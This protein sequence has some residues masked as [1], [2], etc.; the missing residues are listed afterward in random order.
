MRYS[1]SHTK[2]FQNFP[3]YALWLKGGFSSSIILKSKLWWWIVLILSQSPLQIQILVH[4]WASKSS[5]PTS[6]RER[7][8]Y[9]WILVP[10]QTS[11]SS[12]NKFAFG[13]GF[14]GFWHLIISFTCCISSLNCK[15]SLNKNIDTTFNW[16]PQE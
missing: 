10:F 11:L 9:F 4:G 8:D 14:C 15:T 12:E 5:G 7:S 13:R 3:S 16:D 2:N 1:N 6:H